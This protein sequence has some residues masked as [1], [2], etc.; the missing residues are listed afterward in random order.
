LLTARIGN[1]V[2]SSISR[3]H[4]KDL[5]VI[6]RQLQPQIRRGLKRGAGDTLTEKG[7]FDG[8]TSGSLDL[9]VVHRDDEIL[10]GLFLMIE[11]RERGKALIVLDVVAG[12]GHG[13]R[14]Y[15]EDI[16]PRLRE[17]GEMVGAYTIEGVCRLG[18]ARIL[19]RMGCKPKAVIMELNNGRRS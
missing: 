9:W 13:F 19:S 6:W 12:T 11:Q 4:A 10:A 17:Y 8:V 18:T 1:N 2:P 14:H 3:A 5:P 16:V 15:A 7:L